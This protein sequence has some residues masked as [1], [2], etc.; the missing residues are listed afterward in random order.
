M[1]LMRVAGFGWSAWKWIAQDPGGTVWLSRSYGS[2]I[3]ADAERRHLL[4]VVG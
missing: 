4:P 3:A 2:R 1:K